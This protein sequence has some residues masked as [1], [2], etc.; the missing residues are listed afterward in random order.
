M[1][2]AMEMTET[3]DFPMMKTAWGNVP[4][5]FVAHAVVA[6]IDDIWF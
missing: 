2:L 1:L 3:S 6:L 4:T 5:H